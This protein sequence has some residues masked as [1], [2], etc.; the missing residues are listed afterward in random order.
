MTRYYLP[1]IVLISLAGCGRT[2]SVSAPKDASPDLI[3][4]TIET[5]W[6]KSTHRLAL[7]ADSAYTQ[8]TQSSSPETGSDLSPSVS[9]SY[10]GT[11]EL[12]NAFDSNDLESGDLIAARVSIF[13]QSS[14]E[15]TMSEATYT[16]YSGSKIDLYKDEEIG[17][18][19]TAAPHDFN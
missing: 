10:V 7:A 15:T 4:V 8:F 2:T 6:A 11:V 18:T 12:K 13:D 5:S 1:L 3:G 9:V 16:L 19:V 17:L 14:K